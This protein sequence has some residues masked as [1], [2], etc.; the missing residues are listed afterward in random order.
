[1]A[2][3]LKLRSG[4]TDGCSAPVLKVRSIGGAGALARLALKLRP[5]MRAGMGSNRLV[6]ELRSRIST[7]DV[8]ARLAL[9]LRSR[10]ADTCSASI[11]W[12]CASASARTIESS[13]ASSSHR[14]RNRASNRS[15]R[16]RPAC[17]GSS[18]LTVHKKPRPCWSRWTNATPSS[19]IHL[20][21]S[22]AVERPACKSAAAY[23]LSRTKH[24]CVR[25]SKSARDCS[26]RGMGT[27][28]GG[29]KG[30]DRRPVGTCSRSRPADFARRA[31][32]FASSSTFCPWHIF[33]RISKCHACGTYAHSEE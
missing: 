30:R 26:E 24:S 11:S 13:M 21:P 16:E 19:C 22:A 33:H 27:N 10:D 2:E 1:L 17:A 8:S 4:R 28:T 32:N 31:Q 25:S 15:D 20:S 7:G 3:T 6:L 9:K 5:R 23:A 29:E 18:R 12:V 14:L